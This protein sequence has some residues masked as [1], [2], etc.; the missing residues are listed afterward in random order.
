[1]LRDRI[2]ERLPVAGRAVKI[3]L[4]DDESPGGK[5]L[6]VP[7]RT[8]AVGPGT[9]WAAMDEVDERIFSGRVERRRFLYPAEDRVALCA[10]EAELLERRQIER[11]DGGIGLV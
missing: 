7:P 6:I 3:H 2:G 4:G 1:M 8:P 9:L 11:G 5:H 10:D